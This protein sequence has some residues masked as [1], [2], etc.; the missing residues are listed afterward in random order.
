VRKRV[1]AWYW[2]FVWITLSPAVTVPLSFVILGLSPEFSSADLGRASGWREV[3]WY[4][5]DARLADLPGLLNL[6]ALAWLAC[7]S[8][9]TKRAALLAGLLGAIRVAVP[10]LILGAFTTTY[11]GD[12]YVSGFPMLLSGLCSIGL[13]FL[14]AAPLVLFG[15]SSLIWA[16]AG[17][18][19]PRKSGLP[20]GSA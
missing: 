18:W 4:L 8:A 20:P 6:L 16:C 10:L 13:W 12:T 14:T 19:V 2:P 5:R 9:Q 1:D 3:F 15:M 7:P 11:Q 17:R